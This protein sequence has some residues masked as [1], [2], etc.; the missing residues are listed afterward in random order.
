[1]NLQVGD[2]L[3]YED[4][5]EGVSFCIVKNVYQKESLKLFDVCWLVTRGFT[6]C[7]ESQNGYPTVTSFSRRNGWSKLS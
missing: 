2:L 4:E 6:D 1:M 7:E 3:K 5:E